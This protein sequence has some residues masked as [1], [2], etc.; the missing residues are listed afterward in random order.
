MQ[1]PRR[2]APQR[3]P[4]FR[5]ALLLCL[6]PALALADP[7]PS[8]DHIIDQAH[9]LPPEARMALIGKLKNLEERSNIQ[10][11]VAT[12]D[13]LQDQDIKDYAKGLMRAWSIADAKKV[14]FVIAPREHKMR[15]EVGYGL[16]AALTDARSQNLLTTVVAPRF[17]AGDFPGG[18]ERGVDAMIDA[19]SGGATAPGQAD[20]LDVIIPVM[21]FILLFLFALFAFMR[22][23]ERRTDFCEGRHDFI[24]GGLGRDYGGFRDGSA[25]GGGASADW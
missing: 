20:A 11:V 3:R 23:R 15:I 2:F 1:S 8:P 10:L 12:V 5:A 19:L 14:L 17:K 16:G 25:S 13:S 22:S 9:I 18:V 4:L 24:D 21:L 6:V 7:S